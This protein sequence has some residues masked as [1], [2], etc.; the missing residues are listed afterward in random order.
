MK[1]TDIKRRPLADT[2]LASL[3]PEAKE[4]RETYGVDRIYFVVSPNGRKRWE[5]RYKKANGKW[6]FMGLGGYPEVS[7]K[8]AREK[9]GQ[10]MDLIDQGVDPVEKKVSETEQVAKSLHTTF[11]AAA[12]SWYDKKSKEGL[13]KGTLDK[14]RTYLDKDILPT[15][16]DQQLD[17]ITRRDCAALQ[18]SFEVRDAH[19]VAKKARGW[20]NKIFGYAIASG[21]TEN[22]PASE[23]LVVAAPAPKTQ[24]Y[25]HLLEPELPEFMRAMRKSTSRLIARTA[26]WMT[27][28]T[29]SRPGM[30]RYAEWADIDLDDGLW[31][32]SAEKMKMRRDHVVP[33]CTQLVAALKE[34]H[35]LTGR[36][37]WLFPGIG[38]STPVISENTI[39]KVFAGVGY[40][41]R[42]VGHGTRHTASTLLREHEWNK[43]FV[44]AQL[45]HKEAGVSGVY[46]KAAYLRQRRKMMQWYADYLEA[47]E[48]GL[49][50]E[51]QARFAY[52]VGDR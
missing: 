11:R 46:N 32:I 23:L 45:A 42:L 20:L 35:E 4:Y 39:G 29:A 28:W 2:V 49:T 41:G 22:N 47:L 7:A 25:P 50:D 36:G 44:E 40:K 3:E 15:L 12:E 10:A 19:N 1:R 38:S 5:L 48:S 13:A 27:L 52:Q 21:L 34:L 24:Q 37:K 26:A 18:Q 8:K 17:K 9:A 6:S 14:V 30:V 33:L 43:D 51:A 31:S 16:G